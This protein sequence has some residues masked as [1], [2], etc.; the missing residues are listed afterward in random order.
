MKKVSEFNRIVKDIKTIKVQGAENVAKAG[1]K[2]YLLN[3]TESGI[4]KILKTRPTEPL[5]QNSIQSLRKSNNK[6]D[7]AKLL[8]KE[9]KA[10]HNLIAKK[11]SQFIKNGMKV[12]THCHSSTVID[13]LKQAKKEGKK[14]TVYTT[15]VEPLL[16]GRMT[17]K[18][19]AKAGIKVT[20]APDLA[21]ET[22]IKESD[23]ILFGVDAF[24]KNS[25]A[26]KIG[27]SLICRLAQH[28]NVPRFACGISLKYTNKIKIE[29]RAGREVWQD[30]NP[31]IDVIY[32]AFDKV[33]YILLTGIISEFGATRPKDFVKKAKLKVK[34]FG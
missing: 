3:P 24:S 9:I 29:K 1:I 17:A 31:K 14:F 19:L 23:I 5:L 32:P 12:F 6:N 4:K 27:T 10:S 7:T 15:E 30:N 28:Y 8:L 26:N 25:L 22:L 16:Q 33:K 34:K 2:A 13:I 21:A 18:D 11:G 20:V